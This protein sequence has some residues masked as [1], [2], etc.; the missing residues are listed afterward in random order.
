M[1][2]LG[3]LG[4]EVSS[5]L[6]LMSLSYDFSTVV[7]ESK[8]ITYGGAC[9]VSD[10]MES[11]SEGS[12]DGDAAHFRIGDTGMGIFLM[13]SLAGASLCLMVTWVPGGKGE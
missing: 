3:D 5:L 2:L 7:P 11:C 4:V 9:C 10:D 6:S 8:R 13:A 12:M 1:A